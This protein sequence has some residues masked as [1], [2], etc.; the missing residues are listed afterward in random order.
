MKVLVAILLLASSLSLTA[1]HAQT[2]RQDQSRSDPSWVLYQKAERHFRHREFSRAL[3]LFGDALALQPIFP[4]AMVGMARVYR[5]A[6]DT[7]LAIRY[8][9]EALDDARHM[10]IPDEQFAV[11]LELAQLYALSHRAQDQ[12]A[13]REQ[14]DRVVAMDPIFSRESFPEQRDAMR[15]LLYRGGLD[16]VLVLYR[17]S[18]PQAL[19]AHRQL[20]LIHLEAGSEDAHD[21]AV[22]HLLFA[23]VEIAGRAVRALIDIRY[24]YEFTS[25]AEL[26]ER[27]REHPEVD[28][29]LQNADFRGVLLDLAEALEGSGN[30]NGVTRAAEIRSAI[31]GADGS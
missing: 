5:A 21:I 7:T 31:A 19:D 15:N 9:R 20:G 4:E 30:N 23:A 10:I 3:E 17:L 13:R 6:G 18:F 16:R 26:L 1:G 12:V 2:V 24:D 28:E 25:V 22:E 14:L 11:R 8:Y 27:S 29:Y